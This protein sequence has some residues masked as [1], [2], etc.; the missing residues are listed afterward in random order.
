MTKK[1]NVKKVK[2]TQTKVKNK[3]DVLKKKTLEEMN[4]F[5]LNQMCLIIKDIKH[6]LSSSFVKYGKG[7]LD[8]SI[9]SES[10]L[11]T[12]KKF[13]E[14][15]DLLGKIEKIIEEKVYTEYVQ[16]N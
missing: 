14:F 12:L 2:S 8:P 10:E 11:E 16:E 5:E 4:I 6:R 1:E 15:Q 3:K 7:V 13:N 9:M